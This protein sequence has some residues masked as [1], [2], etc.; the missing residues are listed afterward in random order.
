MAYSDFTLSG[1]TKQFQLTIDEKSDLFGDVPEVALREQFA[2][3]L[4]Q[5][6]PLALAISTE[7]ARSELIIAPILVEL[8]LLTGQQ[9]GFFSGVEFAIDPA[10]G[11]TGVCDYIITRSPEQL[12]IKAPVLMLVEAKNEDMKRGY[13]QCTAEMIAAQAFNEREGNAGEKIYGAVTIGNMWKFLELDGMT[14]RIDSRD[15]YIE[16]PGKIMGILLH[17]AGS[18]DYPPDSERF[19]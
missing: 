5:M 4:N 1:L 8:W 13:A 19:S 15:Y 17:L 6:L 16:R 11:L 10:K 18:S 14:V 12:F 2:A 3:H 9:I 7:K